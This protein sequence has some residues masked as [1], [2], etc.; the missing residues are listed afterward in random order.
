MNR[1]V[2]PAFMVTLGTSKLTSRAMIRTVRSTAADL[3]GAPK[4]NAVAW[5]DDVVEWASVGA[6]K[7]TVAAKAAAANAP[8]PSGR[9][10]RKAGDVVG[11][12]D[13]Q[14]FSLRSGVSMAERMGWARNAA[15][16]RL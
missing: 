1:T 8:R 9:I 4:A 5:R 16:S 7:P 14:C 10:F 2:S 15:T 6:A 3:P 13:I 12:L 11:G